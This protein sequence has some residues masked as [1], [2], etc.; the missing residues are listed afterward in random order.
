MFLWLPYISKF[1]VT[2]RHWFFPSFLQCNFEVCHSVS[3]WARVARFSIYIDKWYMFNHK[4][5]LLSLQGQGH[6]LESSM[7][8]CIQKDNPIYSN[9]FKIYI[10][11]QKN[12]RWT[13]HILRPK[14]KVYGC[15]RII[16]FVFKRKIM[17]YW[18]NFHSHTNIRQISWIISKGYCIQ[19]VFSLTKMIANRIFSFKIKYQG[20]QEV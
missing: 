5:D 10:T 17:I 4:K 7:K 6:I 14:F 19:I 11:Y 12:N 18:V 2:W 3:F 20:E 1:K 16:F 9:V 15:H 13:F 8:S